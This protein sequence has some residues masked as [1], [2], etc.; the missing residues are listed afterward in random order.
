MDIGWLDRRVTL[1]SNT[2]ETKPS[3]QVVQTPTTVATVWAK[4]E[5][6][7]GRERYQNQQLTSVDQVSFI[8]RYRTDIKPDWTLECE[9]VAYK[10]RALAE[11]QVK[12]GFARRRF[13]RVICESQY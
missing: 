6:Q 9:G 10:I 5:A 2:E 13:L 4:R 7:G 8:I 3:G 12:A 11:A 1:K